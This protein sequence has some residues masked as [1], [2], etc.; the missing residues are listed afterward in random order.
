MTLSLPQ[1]CLCLPYPQYYKQTSK[2]TRI[3]TIVF[4]VNH[5]AITFM[6][7]EIQLLILKSQKKK[8]KPRIKKNTKNKPK[9]PD[10][11]TLMY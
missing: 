8:K 2:V 9:N 7:S 5:L 4:Y 10:A 1:P 11:R 3:T 6:H